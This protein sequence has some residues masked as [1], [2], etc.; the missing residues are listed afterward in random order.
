M[1]FSLFLGVSLRNVVGE[2]SEHFCSWAYRF[3]RHF[4]LLR[5]GKVESTRKLYNFLKFQKI[6]KFW[7]KEQLNLNFKL[8]LKAY[9]EML[10]CLSRLPPTNSNENQHF[11]YQKSTIRQFSENLPFEACNSFGY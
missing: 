11:H 7:T 9:F 6:Q 5:C 1:F 10:P 2:E 4:R 8:V 3:S